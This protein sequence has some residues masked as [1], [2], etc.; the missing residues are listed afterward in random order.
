MKRIS[1]IGLAALFIVAFGVGQAFADAYNVTTSSG[2]RVTEKGTCEQVGATTIQGQDGVADVFNANQTITIEL[3]AGATICSNISTYY[4]FGGINP[5]AY[6]PTTAMDPANG[7]YVVVANA[8]DD[9]YNIYVL[10]ASAATDQIR[11]GH[12]AAS[13]TCFDLVNTP[14]ISTDPTLQKVEVTYRDDQTPQSTFTGDFV[15]ATVKPKTITVTRCTKTEGSD[16]SVLGWGSF[17]AFN[18]NGVV[19]IPLCSSAEQDQ[20]Q[21]GLN[22]AY[23]QVCIKVSDLTT[24]AFP[25]GTHQFTVGKTTGAKVGVGIAG[26][27]MIYV[28]PTGAESAI[29]TTIT[30]RLKRD[31]TEITPL[32]T[33][34]LQDWVDT[35]QITFTADTQGPGSYYIILSVAFDTCTATTGDWLV[36]VAGFRIPCG[37]SFT[38]TDLVVANFVDCVGLVSSYQAIFP[39]AA[40][41]TLGWYNGV[42]ITNPN[43]Q[44]I[45]VTFVIYEWDGDEYSASV[46]VPAHGQVVGEATSVLNPQPVGPESQFGDEPYWMIGS[47]DLPFY[48]TLFMGEGIQAFGYIAINPSLVAIPMAK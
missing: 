17:D 2:V 29:A 6:D 3:L 1:I 42:V 34:D 19:L 18:K 33:A 16:L 48:G 28:D 15:V 24:G 25:A 45:T 40:Q 44:E 9:F 46:T 5:V 35:S 23:R 27:S 31:G 11:V 10:T 20:A 26:V 37:G 38:E 4:Q 47:S 21:C 43:N 30:K 8:G 36:D 12:D 14:Y 41:Q 22:T 39:Y 13:R 7:D 32:P